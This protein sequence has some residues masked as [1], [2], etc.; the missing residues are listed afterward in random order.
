MLFQCFT[1]KWGGGSFNIEI[2]LS[3]HGAEG[4]LR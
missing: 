1:E 4:V 2:E 3:I